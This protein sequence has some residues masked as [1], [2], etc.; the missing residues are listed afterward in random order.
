MLQ[1]DA[2]YVQE[3]TRRL[4][5]TQRN[6]ESNTEEQTREKTGKEISQR[7]PGTR[8]LQ[9]LQPQDGASLIWAPESGIWP[10]VPLPPELAKPFT[11]GRR[12]AECPALLALPQN[13]CCSPIQG[14][15]SSLVLL[16][17]LT[18]VLLLLAARVIMG[19]T[20]IQCGPDEYLHKNLC[21]KNC[22][23][24]EY[25]S[26]H[27]TRNHHA[28]KCEACEHETY[29]AH[30]SGLND[31]LPCTQ[32]REDQEVVT[33]CTRTRNRQCQCR[34]GFYC[35]QADCEMCR[36]CLRCPEGTVIRHPCNATADTVCVNKKGNA[37]LYLLFMIIPVLLFTVY[38][39]C[40][41]RKGTPP[42][43]T[44]IS[45]FEGRYTLFVER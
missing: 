14:A 27:C 37:N 19:D 29:M 18:R 31:C 4:C 40:C 2:G 9:P 16:A 44:V 5:P 15:P 43:S 6:Q 38:I 13:A 17:M 11:E 1:R 24:G 22:A 20:R 36:A 39:Y 3:I 41:K 30:S 12:A 35:E 26:K 7:C 21:C 28:G 32:C 23:S 42:F 34:T 8:Q 33:N 10:G 45:F 25:L